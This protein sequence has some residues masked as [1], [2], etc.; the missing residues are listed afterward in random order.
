MQTLSVCGVGEMGRAALGVDLIQSI[1]V[2]R[3]MDSGIGSG[4]Q[5]I[6]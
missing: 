4:V 5:G 6:N 3:I 1:D 2:V